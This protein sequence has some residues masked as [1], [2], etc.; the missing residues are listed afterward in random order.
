MRYLLI[1]LSL[2]LF[3]CVDDLKKEITRTYDDGR[4]QEVITYKGSG[5]NKILIDKT[6]FNVAGQIIKKLQYDTPSDYK[7]IYYY[8]NG[9]LEGTGYNKNN[10]KH[11][12]WIWYHFENSQIKSNQYWEYGK[13]VS[14]W[15]DYYSNGQIRKK[16]PY[17]IHKED[18][19]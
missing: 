1:V 6:L 9:D 2:F 11:G 17:L 16:V 12:H 15:I 14:E 3:S 7:S 8:I 5:K 13:K 4:T 10:T 18:G 19:K